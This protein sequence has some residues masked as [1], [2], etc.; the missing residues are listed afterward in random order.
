M[1][2][3]PVPTKHSPPGQAARVPPPDVDTRRKGD[4]RRAPAEGPSSVVGLIGPIS[5]QA[6][7]LRLRRSG[8]RARRGP[9]TVTWVHDDRAGQVRVA[10]AVGRAV[11]GAVVRNRVRRRLRA[12]VGE[13][14]PTLRPGA[15][16]VG[17]LPQAASTP[18][19]EL[20][21][22]VNEALTSLT[23]ARGAVSRSRP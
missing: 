21:A 6:T 20:R 2:E 16:L 4:R 5:D 1:G 22:A 8:R 15:Y 12:V 18:Y 13:L 11:G 14:R 19:G 17:A 10:Y 3:T 7:F 23:D 9:V